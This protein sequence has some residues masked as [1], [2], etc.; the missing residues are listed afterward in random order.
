MSDFDPLVRQESGC[1][2]AS[3]GA[4]AIKAER[5]L[6]ARQVEKMLSS[7]EEALLLVS[8]SLQEA[9]DDF[10]RAVAEALLINSTLRPFH[11]Q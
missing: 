1:Q 5:W 6:K 10:F 4:I 2:Q 11:R 9:H 7:D 8:S 3:I